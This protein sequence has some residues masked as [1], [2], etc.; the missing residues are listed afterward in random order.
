MAV[1]KGEGFRVM[2]GMIAC[3]A[4][5][6]VIGKDGKMPWGN[7][8]KDDLAFFKKY[9]M[10]KTV[11]M[12]RKTYRSLPGGKPLSGRINIVMSRH[13]TL[14]DYPAGVMLYDSPES[15]VEYAATGG[16]WV[17]VLGGGELY[18]SFLDKADE[19]MLTVI[20]KKYDGDTYFPEWDNI[21][22]IFPVRKRVGGGKD[23]KI[24]S[25][26]IYKYT[27]K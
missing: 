9:T 4:S 5:N 8:F 14:S 11:V 12:G 19:L 25:Y 20:H 27:R 24:G 6:G 16:Q 18:R 23:D 2:I 26:T 22:K 1:D 15:V 21:D 3:V 13:S 10:G 7:G 17:V